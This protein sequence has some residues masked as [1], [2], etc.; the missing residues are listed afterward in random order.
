MSEL[1][2][3]QTNY[4]ARYA[5]YSHVYSM[6]QRRVLLAL[7]WGEFPRVFFSVVPYVCAQVEVFNRI[8]CAQ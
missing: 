8:F 5:V 6:V 7:V 1:F 2:V 4:V 3:P